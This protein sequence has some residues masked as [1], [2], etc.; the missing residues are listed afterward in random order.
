MEKQMTGG[1]LAGVGAEL[2]PLVIQPDHQQLFM[3]SAITW[4][5][6]AI[7]YNRQCARDEGLPD[8][9]VQRALIG[10]YFARLLERGTHHRAEILR[11]EWK[12]VRSAIP[13]DT[14]T[15][16]GVVR[17]SDRQQAATLIEC[18]LTMVNQQAETVANGVGTV[19][20]AG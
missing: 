6:H 16:S 1:Y 4:N 13:G 19:R 12:V 15:C 9:V 17:R 5:R 14:L 20:L 10:N 2:E 7:H 18:D 3:F 8:V 11:L